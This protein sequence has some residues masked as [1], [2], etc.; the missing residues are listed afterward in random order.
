MGRDSPAF[1]PDGL[2]APRRIRWLL[3][4][5]YQALVHCDE[6]GREFEFRMTVVHFRADGFYQ[7]PRKTHWGSAKKLGMM[8]VEQF[9]K[10]YFEKNYGKRANNCN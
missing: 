1:E 4:K 10:F 5:V 7:P 3:R 9:D 8:K 2:P 6:R